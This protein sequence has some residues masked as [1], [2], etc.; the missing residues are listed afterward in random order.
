MAGTGS[1]AVP[2]PPVPP[3]PVPPVP[4]TARETDLPAVLVDEAAA[5]G[6]A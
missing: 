5:D 6:C 1:A 4:P 2:P 3:L